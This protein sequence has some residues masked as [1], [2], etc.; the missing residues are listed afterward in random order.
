MKSSHMKE[1]THELRL[2]KWHTYNI[3]MIKI[4]QHYY[5][6][7]YYVQRKLGDFKMSTSK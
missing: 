4:Q 7:D 3:T 6:Q 1:F 2:Q 5:H